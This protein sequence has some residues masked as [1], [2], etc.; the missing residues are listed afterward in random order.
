MKNFIEFKNAGIKIETKSFNV[1]PINESFG[2]DEDIINLADLPVWDLA[3]IYELI[4]LNE[5][6]VLDQLV[7]EARKGL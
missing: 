3:E 5:V 4:S 7:E 1:Y 6:K 2:G